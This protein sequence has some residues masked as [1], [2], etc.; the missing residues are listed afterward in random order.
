MALMRNDVDGIVDNITQADGLSERYAPE[1]V[2]MALSH[3]SDIQRYIPGVHLEQGL[4][5]LRIGT[6]PVL[7]GEILRALGLVGNDVDR[8][9]EARAVFET[10]GAPP[11]AQ[12][13]CA[14]IGLLTDDRTLFDDALGYLESISDEVQVERYLKRWTGR[15]S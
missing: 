8:L 3:L 12:R 13:V 7:R 6:V 5:Q 9:R 14:E 4:D 15:G 11:Y 2:A 1:Y 10:I